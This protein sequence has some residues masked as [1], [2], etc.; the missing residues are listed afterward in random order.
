M[1][2]GAG[3]IFEV[4]LGVRKSCREPLLQI[5]RLN[6]R[7]TTTQ[8]TQAVNAGTVRVRARQSSKARSARMLQNALDQ[9]P[10]DGVLHGR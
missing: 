6:H 8:L 9:G 4:N 3:E 1:V 2:L 5:L 7:R 10:A